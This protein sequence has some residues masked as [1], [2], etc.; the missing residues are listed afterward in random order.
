MNHGFQSKVEF[1]KARKLRFEDYNEYEEFLKSGCNSKEEFEFF[2]KELP[3]FIKR[4]EK[5]IKQTE[6]DAKN[7]FGSKRYEEY[8]RLSFLSIE[9]LS[10]ALYLSLFRR[11][12]KHEDD[13]KVD[14]LI[15]EIGQKLDREL[16]DEEEIK[17]WRRIRNKVVHQNL[18]IPLD[19]AEKGKE[20]FDEIFGIMSK[21]LQEINK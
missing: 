11:E 8:I 14:D 12:F 7:A 10:E 1:D 17:Y 13:K 4:N 16:V 21:I 5:V 15:S 9:K 3:H 19:K 6:K 2:K 20:F 18:K